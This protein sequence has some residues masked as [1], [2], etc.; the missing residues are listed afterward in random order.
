MKKE[1]FHISTISPRLIPNNEAGCCFHNEL[2][3]NAEILFKDESY[4]IAGAM[5]EI[6]EELHEPI[7]Y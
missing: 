3:S 6:Y 1:I 2:V 4:K 5:F 7:A